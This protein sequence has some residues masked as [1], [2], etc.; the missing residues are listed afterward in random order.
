LIFVLHVIITVM[1]VL[2]SALLLSFFYVNTLTVEPL[3]LA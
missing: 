3:H 1:A 2:F